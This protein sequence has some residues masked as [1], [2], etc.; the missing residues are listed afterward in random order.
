M[1]DV[2]GAEVVEGSY[3]LLYERSSESAS[4]AVT[5][6]RIGGSWK[7][8]EGGRRAGS[9]SGKVAT[10]RRRGGRGDVGG[11]EN[12]HGSVPFEVIVA[13]DGGSS[14][15]SGTESSRGEGLGRRGW[16]FDEA[17][18]LLGCGSTELDMSWSGGRGGGRVVVKV[19]VDCTGGVVGALVAGG[20]SGR[21]RLGGGGAQN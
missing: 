5:G 1:Y 9:C 19:G 7:C 6:G 15:W 16:G 3:R 4:L 21:G 17:V 2:R 14:K 18:S 11:D 13:K 8:L 12:G 20:V 10:G